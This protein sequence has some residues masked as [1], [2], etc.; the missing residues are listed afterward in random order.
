M[1]ARGGLWRVGIALA[2]AIAFMVSGL[3]QPFDERLQHEIDGWFPRQASSGVVVIEI[4][5]RSLNAVGSWPWPRSL[6]GKLVDRLHRAGAALI[7]FD[8]DFSAH[9]TAQEDQAFSRALARA[10]DG[11]IL[12]TFRQTLSFDSDLE[13]ENLPI[14]ALRTH[15]FLASVNVRPDADGLVRRYPYGTTTAGIPRPSMSAML[16]GANGTIDSD[17]AIDTAIDPGSVPRLS[18]IDVLN[19][20]FDPAVVKGHAVLI[21]ATAIEMGDRYVVPGHGT[22][23]GV[24]MQAVAAETLIQQTA[25][26]NFGP[27]WPLGIAVGAMA[28]MGLRGRRKR[29]PWIIAG[30]A[31]AAAL[32]PVGCALLGKGTVEIVPAIVFLLAMAAFDGLAAMRAKLNESRLTDTETGLPNARAFVR[33]FASLPALQV[34]D[35]RIRQFE[36][37]NAVLDGAGMARLVEQIATRLTLAFPE[38]EL[39]AVET[40]ALAWGGP[41]VAPDTL[42]QQMAAAAALFVV[43]VQLE[44]RAVLVTPAFGVATGSGVQAR[45]ALAQAGLAARQALAKGARWVVH[46]EGAASQNDR[47]LTLLADVDAA[48][49]RGDIYVRYQPKLAIAEDRICGGEALVRWTHPMFGNVPPDE[50]IPLLEAAGRAHA[51]TFFV[52]DAAIV[53]RDVWLA[54]GLDL[55][56]A[57]NLSAA[58]LEDAAFVDAVLARLRALGPEAAHFTFEVTESA[59]IARADTAI[60]ALNA[61]RRHGARVSID[62]YGT[63]N[64]TLTYLKAF[65]ADEI[66]IDKSFVTNLETS[67]SDQILVRSTIEMARELGFTVV[68]EGIE[69]EI[70][71]ARLRDYGCAIG[72]GWV[73]GKPMAPEAFLDLARTRNLPAVAA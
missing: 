22:L 32:V 67:T 31:L 62:D 10:G 27:F 16:A 7:G 13:G 72:Q 23:P 53:Q 17:F 60:A 40:G 33:R 37:I 41:P 20:F 57:V 73:I 4:D 63:G 28:V 21:G 64:A 24:V 1:S 49:T 29:R 46:S 36:E 52:L 50:F 48:L 3:S 42:M 11:V 39:H 71:L 69:D 19:G 65:P 12:S 34:I 61:F 54:A 9:S 44:R 30:V 6:H 5:S 2:L 70:C 14:E 15:A 66:K 18:A 47:A 51:L 8:I 38:A 45:D 68:A 56:I 58:L 25:R 59:T 26:R 55:S 43:P 35:V